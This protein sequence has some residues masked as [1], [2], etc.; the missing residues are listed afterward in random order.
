MKR[1]TFFMT[2]LL[3]VLI[4]YTAIF[5][6]C[7]MMWE[8]KLNVQKERAVSEH[9]MVILSAVR[10]MQAMEKRGVDIENGLKELM[11]TYDQ[12]GQERGRALFLYEKEKLLYSSVFKEDAGT[13][14]GPLTA[15]AVE[16]PSI[17]SGGT[18]EKGLETADIKMDGVRQMQ[19]RTEKREEGEALFLFVEGSFPNPWMEYRLVYRYCLT[20]MFREWKQ[21][22][23]TLF[24]IGSLFILFLSVCLS[25]LLNRVFRPLQQIAEASQKIAAGDFKERLVEGREEELVSVAKSF[26]HMAAIIEEQMNALR[27]AAKQKQQ[28]VDNFAHELRTPLTAIYGYAEY[29]QKASLTEED[30]IAA[31]GYIMLETSRLS[32]LAHQLL[33]LAALRGEAITE[34]AVSIRE[35]FEAVQNTMMPKARQRKLELKFS[36]NSSQESLQGSKELLE[37]LLIN[38]IDNGMKASEDG[39][40]IEI[41]AL[42][43][44]ESLILSVSDGGRGMTQE[45]LSHVMEPF[46]RTDKA[47]SRKEGGAGLGLA[48]CL[49]I[50]KIHQAK[51]K[52][53]SAPGEGTVVRIFFPCRKNNKIFTTP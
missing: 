36:I 39:G 1:R 30:K 14:N 41:R 22:K 35:L 44:Q 4:F 5:F 33:D 40:K 6:L 17:E 9:Y 3:F 34:E 48:L 25:W 23:K 8:E 15:E 27:M 20:D 16:I 26:N 32:V 24:F 2:L 49:Q 53:T 29:L 10:D 52:I 46:Y 18:N 38:L 31:A 19:V 42:F 28:M 50:A 51:M 43:V 21:L 37:S 7:I 45:E 11:G 13:E 47:R 12:F